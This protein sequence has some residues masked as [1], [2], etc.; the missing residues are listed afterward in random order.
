MATGGRTKDPPRQ[1]FP[2]QCLFSSQKLKAKL[3][4][5][6]RIHEKIFELLDQIHAV[7][8]RIKDKKV[9][10]QYKSKEREDLV[11]E[12]R[13][14]L[15]SLEF[16]LLS[17]PLSK[18][19]L[20]G[21]DNRLISEL[22]EE[23]SAQ[24]RKYQ[25]TYD[26]LS[27]KD[28]VF[29]YLF[30]SK[31]KY[32]TGIDEAWALIVLRYPMLMLRLKQKDIDNFKIGYE[33]PTR[34]AADSAVYYYPMLKGAG[35]L[36]SPSG[37]K[38]NFIITN[39]LVLLWQLVNSTLD[40]V[41]EWEV[42]DVLKNILSEAQLTIKLSPHFQKES[43]YDSSAEESEEEFIGESLGVKEVFKQ[44]WKERPRI[45]KRE[46]EQLKAQRLKRF[47]KNLSIYTP[48]M[49]SA[50][51]LRVLACRVSNKLVTFGKEHDFVFLW[52]T[53]ET[54]LNKTFDKVCFTSEIVNLVGENAKTPDWIPLRSDQPLWR[55]MVE[56]SKEMLAR[57]ESQMSKE[58][59]RESNPL[60][61]FDAYEFWHR[62][63]IE[64]SKRDAL[65]RNKPFTLSKY[66]FLEEFKKHEWTQFSDFNQTLTVPSY[67]HEGILGAVGKTLPAKHNH[68]ES[69]SEQ[70]VAPKTAA[71]WIAMGEVIMINFLVGDWLYG[72]KNELEMSSILIPFGSPISDK[73]FISLSDSFLSH[74]GYKDLAKWVK[75]RHWSIVPENKLTKKETFLQLSNFLHRFVKA[76]L[77]DIS[78]MGSVNFI[79]RDFFFGLPCS[80]EPFVREAL[81]VGMQ[82]VLLKL[83]NETETGLLLA[84]SMASDFRDEGRMLYSLIHTV[85]YIIKKAGRERLKFKI[86]DRTQRLKGIRIGKDVPTNKLCLLEG[87]LYRSFNYD[88]SLLH[89]KVQIMGTPFLLLFGTLNYYTCQ[90][91]SERLKEDKSIK[92]IIIGY[93]HGTTHLTDTM[94]LG[95]FIHD[96]ALPI[97]LPPYSEA[98]SGG[99]K[100]F[101]GGRPSIAFYPKGEVFEECTKVGVH[102][103][104]N[105]FLNVQAINLP[106]DDERHKPHLQYLEHLGLSP[107]QA[108]N[109]YFFMIQY[110]PSEMHAMT[111]DEV[112][113]Y[114]LFSAIP[115]DKDE[116]LS[117]HLSDWV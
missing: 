67:K 63:K 29:P 94:E 115:L 106:A 76:S 51:S 47:R 5:R 110:K 56:R 117:D 113:K 32:D 62:K 48:L 53:T 34:I 26:D 84:R 103:W 44:F 43:D 109:A 79:S 82:K 88:E 11:R 12:K 16:E 14:L 69:L 21:D 40:R 54:H 72:S 74:F 60:Q 37:G 93:I 85:A 33:T 116:P 1:L 38:N 24:R 27:E 105:D 112:M 41:S 23:V 8:N 73:V 19:S 55:T 57:S 86:W 83:A 68:F 97:Y 71:Y 25:K 114:E 80:K 107:K 101:F 99:S 78:G 100:L 64:K 10:L 61:G 9:L 49:K 4:Q 6:R 90:V 108:R 65:R 58:T 87:G 28:S 70:S 3:K 46:K 31:E 104:R 2:I 36:F 52:L 45:S 22:F 77:G 18:L 89:I 50:G 7:D 13:D 35:H 20:A 91:V 95:K 102:S 42:D 98:N 15:I 17:V 92:G 96:N 30:D 59:G 66:N 111:M 75:H 81:I 39:Y